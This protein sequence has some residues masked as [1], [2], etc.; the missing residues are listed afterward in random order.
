MAKILFYEGIKTEINLSNTFLMRSDCEL[1]SARSGREIIDLAKSVQPDLICLEEFMPDMDGKS[2][3]ERCALQELPTHPKYLLLIEGEPDDQ[4]IHYARKHNLAF[5]TRPIE[6]V[7]LLRQ[8]SRLLDVPIRLAVRLK[9]VF[10]VKG[11]TARNEVFYGRMVD[12]STGGFLLEVTRKLDR[13]DI[14]YCFFNLTR[15]DPLIFSSV[16]IV[17]EADPERTDTYLYGA[18]FVHLRPEDRR[19]IAQYIF[20]QGDD[21]AG[22][23]ASTSE[24]D[25]AADPA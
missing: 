23:D 10:E 25:S 9:V 15:K 12:I 16:E 14:L 18:E 11:K 7:V 5:V 4:L 3:L 2:C 19:Q 1:F 22:R 8:I 20:R 13:G 21:A 24:S 6:Q 17:R